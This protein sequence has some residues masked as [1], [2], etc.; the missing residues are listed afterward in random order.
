MLKLKL[1][2]FSH[3][4]WRTDSFE[5]ALM[6]GKI[7][8]KSRRGWQRMRWLD[9][10]TDSM[11]MSLSELRELAMDREAW[12]AAVYGVA[13]SQ[14]QLNNWTELNWSCFQLLSFLFSGLTVGSGY[15]LMAARWQVFFSSWIP[16]GLTGSIAD[17]CDCLIYWYGR[18]YFIP[19]YYL[20]LMCHLLLSLAPLGY[21]CK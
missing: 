4:T 11:D 19:H 1:Q 6:L 7:E 20:L 13:K 5:T 8:G 21:L 17:S 9:G 2:Y 16:S 15:S 12:H 18:K 3:L 14:T 10:I